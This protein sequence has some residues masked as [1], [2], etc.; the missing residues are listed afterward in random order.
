MNRMMRKKV[1]FL[2]AFVAV[3]LF[4]WSKMDTAFCESKAINLLEDP[5]TVLVFSKES[6]SP[7]HFPAL[8]V[9]LGED[10]EGKGLKQIELSD[11]L[12]KNVEI[13]GKKCSSTIQE[14]ESFFLYFD[15]DDNHSF[16][17]GEKIEVKVFL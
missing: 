14:K 15:V 6:S 4:G 13:G 17:K 2:L 10:A 3:V 7:G 5:S 16:K 11:G 8:W 9:K 12:I 1:V